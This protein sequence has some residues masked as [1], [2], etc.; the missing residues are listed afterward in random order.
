MYF[1]Q[2]FEKTVIRRFSDF[3][4]FY[5]MMTSRFPYRMVTCLPPKKLVGG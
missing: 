2:T 1:L 5:E 4:V 3:V